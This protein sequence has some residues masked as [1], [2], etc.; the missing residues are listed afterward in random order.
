[1]HTKS[2]Q[3]FKKLLSLE[4]S[5]EQS[6]YEK[7]DEKLHGGSLLWF[8]ALREDT[9]TKSYRSGDDLDEKFGTGIRRCGYRISRGQRE[10]VRRLP[11]SQ[12]GGS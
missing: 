11:D 10:R 6:Q 2:P 9:F 7:F 5:L 12:S 3:F 8:E 4:A 1:M